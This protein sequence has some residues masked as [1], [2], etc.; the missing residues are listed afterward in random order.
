[1]LSA[2]GYATC[3]AFGAG[4]TAACTTK[5]AGDISC[6]LAG[7]LQLD[8]KMLRPEFFDFLSTGKPSLDNKNISRA[9]VHRF[10]TVRCTGMLPPI[11]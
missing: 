9:Y 8:V 1:M 2:K 5:R 4:S 6:G 7:S 11:R 3:I 10:L